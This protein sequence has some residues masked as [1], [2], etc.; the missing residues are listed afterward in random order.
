M[1]FVPVPHNYA[2]MIATYYTTLLLL[3]LTAVSGVHKASDN[4]DDGNTTH[5]HQVVH[6]VF[7]CHLVRGT[8]SSPDEHT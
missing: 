4:D 7:S 2:V 1:W 8:A 5:Q 6:I 3:L